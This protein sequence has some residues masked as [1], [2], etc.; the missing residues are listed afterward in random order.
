MSIT[1]FFI[2]IVGGIA[3]GLLGVGGA[4]V[5]IPLMLSV[6]PLVGSG[7]LSMNEVAGITMIQV[8]A[9][10]IFGFMTHRNNGQVHTKTI[11]YIGIPM[12]IFSLA[13]AIFSKVMNEQSMLL[14]FG[15]LVVIAFI[16]LLK[17]TSGESE[18]SS[19]D[20]RFNGWLSIFIG[21]S[22][23][24]ASGII[25]AGG[26]FIIIP[27][28][29][30]I[31]KIPL[32]IT[33]G[34]SLGIVLIGA[35]MG[36]IGKIVSFQVDLTYLLPVIAGSIPA[37]ILGARLSKKLPDKYIHYTLTTVVFLIMVKTWSLIAICFIS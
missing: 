1:L 34:S 5:L 25:G 37:A 32:K 20:F 10:S 36:S 13:G 2:S 12:G 31:L 18:G 26:G 8:L 21:S 19:P 17:K 30:R 23:G 28:M 9:A 33:I 29:L 22:V 15:F 24:L 27:L 35:L 11:L 16:L 14:I 6:P 3:S 7:Q 4:V